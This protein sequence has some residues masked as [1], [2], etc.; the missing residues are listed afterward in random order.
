M[1]FAIFVGRKYS[2]VNK[3]INLNNK[4]EIVELKA[5]RYRIYV[6][7]GFGV[8]IGQSSI[9]FKHKETSEITK[10]KKSFW[11]V[12]TYAFEKRA[13]RIFIADIPKKGLY[14]V[15]LNK[16]ETIRVQSSNLS[17]ISLFKKPLNNSKVEILITEKLDSFPIL[18][19]NLKF[20]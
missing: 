16:P 4:G 14:E 8:N 9:D 7:G 2:S 13:K 3:P 15:V 17:I 12:Q 11:P 18:N 6:L 1:E 19:K 5:H 20:G 10:C